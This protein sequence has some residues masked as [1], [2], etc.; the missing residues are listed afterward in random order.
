MEQIAKHRWC[1]CYH[2]WFC[3]GIHQVGF[4]NQRTS[5]I[6]TGRLKLVI[7]PFGT[8]WNFIQHMIDKLIY[9][10]LLWSWNFGS[11]ARNTITSLYAPVNHVCNTAWNLLPEW[12]STPR[13]WQDKNCHETSHG[14]WKFS[15]N[16]RASKK[17]CYNERNCKSERHN[18]NILSC[19]VN[20][21]RFTIWQK[22]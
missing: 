7:I 20:H 8:G 14:A 10:I 3:E 12:N 2:H 11:I 9:L 21:R 22:Q 17:L 13:L 19:I 5:N 4:L 1:W 15:Q 6:S 16:F 18:D